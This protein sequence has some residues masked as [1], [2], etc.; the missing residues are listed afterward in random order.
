MR[1]TETNTTA[2]ILQP[3]KSS[4]DVIP[5]DGFSDTHLIWSSLPFVLFI[6]IRAVVRRFSKD[7]MELTKDRAESDVIKVLQDESS[8]LRDSNDK[9]RSG[10]ERISEERNTAVSQLGKFIA[11]TEANKTRVSELQASIGLMAIKLDEQ[12]DLLQKVLLENAQL[13][14]QVGHLEQLNERLERE[15]GNLETLINK[16][17]QNYLT[18]PDHG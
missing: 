17:N 7:S 14:S 4:P 2:V 6:I 9:L 10:I 12:T 11:E 8:K 13:K 5:K 18:K 15:V 3:S 1:T 16:L